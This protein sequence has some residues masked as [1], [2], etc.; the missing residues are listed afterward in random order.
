MAQCNLHVAGNT[1]AY[2]AIQFCFFFNRP[3]FLFCPFIHT[4]VAPPSGTEIS[5]ELSEHSI[6]YL[7]QMDAQ[8][9]IVSQVWEESNGSIERSDN[10]Q[11]EPIDTDVLAALAYCQISTIDNKGADDEVSNRTWVADI[12]KEE[13]EGEAHHWGRIA[14]RVCV[15]GVKKTT[16]LFHQMP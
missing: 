14:S 5:A 9:W 2:T 4:A 16:V 6:N 11:G 8:K 7:L 1:T 10:R 13:S 12:P 15:R 3:S